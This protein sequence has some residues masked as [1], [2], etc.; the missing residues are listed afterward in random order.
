MKIAIYIPDPAWGHS[1]DE[2]YESDSLR[3][4]KALEKE[5][6]VAFKRRNIGPGADLFSFET[7][8]PISP[9]W[10]LSAP[11]ALFFL[12]KKI[13]NAVE[14]WAK[15]F[16]K[17]ERFLPRRPYLNRDAAGIL[18]IQSL[19]KE[20]GHFPESI[21]LLGYTTS[22]PMTDKLSEDIA[23]FDFSDVTQ[24]Y[25]APEPLYLMQTVHVFK[26]KTEHGLYGIF[27][28]RNEVAIRKLA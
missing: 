16:E 28:Y 6:K 2:E 12:G 10:S 21:E 4:R 19:S 23:E 8:I 26:C 3:S 22:V 20:L 25:G 7:W 27:V 18:A 15:L 17:I 9:W 14:G 11:L 1:S 5:F 13:N 24:I